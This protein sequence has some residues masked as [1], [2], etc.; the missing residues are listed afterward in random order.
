MGRPEAAQIHQHHLAA[1]QQLLQH[2]LP[3]AVVAAEF[4]HAEAAVTVGLAWTSRRQL[5]HRGDEPLAQAAFEELDQFSSA[6]SKENPTLA[7][8]CCWSCSRAA[9]I[10]PAPPVV[11]S[12]RGG[13]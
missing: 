8:R 7:G 12:R 10:S 13:R 9:P 11:G 5:I 4:L 2:R 3:A 6:R 1:L